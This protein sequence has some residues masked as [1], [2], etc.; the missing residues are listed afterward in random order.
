MRRNNYRHFEATQ[1]EEGV[2]FNSILNSTGDSF[3][4]LMRILALSSLLDALQGLRAYWNDPSE[5]KEHL[6][7]V[8]N[9]Y[10]SGGPFQ[11]WTQVVL[12][13]KMVK[14][15]FFSPKLIWI[16]CV[17]ISFSCH[18]KRIHASTVLRGVLLSSGFIA[19]VRLRIVTGYT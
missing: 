14:L 1:A 17:K 15:P 8:R 4:I 7:T 10:K 13:Y 9:S 3:A 5:L 16:D 2:A 19:A 11:V 12:K 6:R 18:C